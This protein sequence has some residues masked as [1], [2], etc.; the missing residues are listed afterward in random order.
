MP[1]ACRICFRVLLHEKL[2]RVEISIGVE[3]AGRLEYDSRLH[4]VFQ[5]GANFPLRCRCRCCCYC[6][7]SF[8]VNGVKS[9]VCVA[10]P[11][12][13]LLKVDKTGKAKM[14]P[15]QHT[16]VLTFML[17]FLLTILC[18]ALKMN[19]MLLLE[20]LHHCTHNDVTCFNADIS[21]AHLLRT[22]IVL[23]FAIFTFKACFFPVGFC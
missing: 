2:N 1:S 3:F 5:P 10:N 21:Q 12:R 6:F 7:E 11:V 13:R 20:I 18:V 23:R 17:K 15:N 8:L 9:M 19:F 16:I 4:E 14:A 22:P